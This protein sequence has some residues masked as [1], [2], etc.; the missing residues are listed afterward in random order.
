MRKPARQAH[1]LMWIIIAPA[2]IALALVALSRAPSTDVYADPSVV[3][4]GE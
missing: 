1:L 3:E 4:A 2:T